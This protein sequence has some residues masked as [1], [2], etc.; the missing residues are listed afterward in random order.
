MTT[1]RR[2]GSLA[3]LA[4]ALAGCQ[5]ASPS[6]APPASAPPSA[7]SSASPAPASG[8]VTPPADP[9]DLEGAWEGELGDPGVS[10]PVT[11]RLSS[12]ALGQACGES[13]YPPP[14]DPQGTPLCAAE[15]TLEE[16]RDDAFVLSER[17]VFQP[18]ECLASNMVVRLAPD[19]A[20]AVEQYGDLTE[21]PFA[22][23]TLARTAADA[24]PTPVPLAAPVPGLGTPTAA[25]DLE[26]YTTQYTAE[27]FGS[28]WLPLDGRG[29]VI[30]VDAATGAEQAR[31]DVGGDPAAVDDLHSDPHSVAASSDGIWVTLVADHAIGFID[32]ATDTLGRRIDL[33]VEPYAMAIDGGDAW[34]TS[35]TDDVLVKVDLEGGQVTESIPVTKPTGVA[36]GAGGVWVVEHR[37]NA[38][39]MVRPES[40]TVEARIEL[41][42]ER[43]NDLCGFCV[44]N[45]IV[46]EGSVWTADNE[47]RSVTRIDPRKL[48]VEAHID[49]PLRVWA[50]AAGGGRIWA[51]QF[52]ESRT[53]ATDPASTWQTVAIDPATNLATSYDLPSQS[54]AW[55]GD[56]LWVVQPDRR[57]D[58]LVR[59]EL[60]P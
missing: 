59:V 57:S 6:S 34:V 37:S 11:V 20:L 8:P 15:L 10:Y 1:A 39:V 45:I 32:P 43:P 51:S 40:D 4:L 30:R 35:F 46:A 22:R 29:E 48:A 21:P 14:A 53:P 56:A 33:G 58:V 27:G 26:G 38:V 19:G 36:V 16:I 52:D 44:E 49:L 41:G 13:E 25:L 3:V 24:R 7:A 12:C 55:A 60:E 42:E 50:V 5:A 47:R 18:W 28:L 2:I 54:V 23:G 31:L 9:G 17:M